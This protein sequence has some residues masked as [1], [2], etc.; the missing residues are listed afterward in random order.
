MIIFW[1]GIGWSVLLI[2]F[3]WLF[4]LIGVAIATMGPGPDPN[5][6]ANTNRLFAAAF[7]LAAGTVFYLARGRA[8]RR[9]AGAAIEPD[10]FMF[11]RMEYWT[12]PLAAIAVYLAIRSLAG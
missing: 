6:E 12:W 11:I 10:E 2:L 7:A 3:G 8:K 9:Q 4:L 1:R 5:A